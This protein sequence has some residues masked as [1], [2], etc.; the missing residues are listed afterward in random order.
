MRRVFITALVSLLLWSQAAQCLAQSPMRASK[1]D[2]DALAAALRLAGGL[3]SDSSKETVLIR[4]SQT[5]AKTG[6]F[7]EAARAL[8]LMDD[9]VEKAHALCEL[10]NTLADAGKLDR[11]AELLNETL[12]TLRRVCAER[13]EPPSKYTLD[14]LVV[15]SESWD[16]EAFPPRHVTG[17]GALARLAEAGR[18][19]EVARLLSLAKSVALDFESDDEAQSK[20]F[21]N[22]ARVYA[23]TGDASKAEEAL[24]DASEAARRVESAYEKTLALCE[25]ADAYAATGDRKRAELSLAEALQTASTLEQERDRALRRV[26]RAYADAKFYEQARDAARALSDEEG[27]RAFATLAALGPESKPADLDA[28]LSDAVE[29]A[30]SLEDEGS[31]ARALEGLTS[32]YGGRAPG[33]LSKVAEAAS[34]LLAPRPRAEVLIS[35]GDRHREAGRKEAALEF[36]RRALA[37]ARAVRLRREDLTEGDSR[38]NDGEKLDLLFALAR[39][40]ARSGAHELAREIA[41]DAEDVQA[42]AL[43]LAEG[44][45]AY[46]R[47]AGPR[48]AE[49]GLILLRAGRRADA[50]EVL[51]AASRAASKG[52]DGVD[53]HRRVDALGAVAAAYAKAGERARAELHFRRALEAA[54]GMELYGDADALEVLHN[55]GTYYAEAGMKPDAGYLKAMRRLVRKVEEEIE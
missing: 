30:V 35:V 18:A 40:L 7:D 48:L 32:T 21:A 43:Q 15:G 2:A 4:L 5:Y 16:Y 37:S 36:W 22:S 9:G 1:P 50:L 13:E 52:G 28:A 45:P 51:E 25:V 20:L 17:K 10:A 33:A 19:E 11:A 24:A 6:R 49:L 23:Q 41:R 12:L 31:K 42:R 14:S 47:E 26:V 54:Q 46:V 27:E 55:V 39:R 44:A 3:G 53:E 8:S 34:R 38:I 29:A